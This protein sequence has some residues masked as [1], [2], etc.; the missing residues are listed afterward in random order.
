LTQATFGLDHVAPG[1]DHDPAVRRQGQRRFRRLTRPM[2]LGFATGAVGL[3]V[4]LA[5]VAG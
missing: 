4:V 2:L 3:L 1:G 5:M